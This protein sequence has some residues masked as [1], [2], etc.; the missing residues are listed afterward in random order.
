MNDL[1][2]YLSYRKK[3]DDD[4]YNNNNTA[5]PSAVPKLFEAK[6]KKQNYSR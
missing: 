2:Y 6:E 5:M 4:E 1:S 3:I